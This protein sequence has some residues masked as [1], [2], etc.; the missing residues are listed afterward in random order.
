MAPNT[1]DLDTLKRQL[2]RESWASREE[3]VSTSERAGKFSGANGTFNFNAA[4][5]RTG[6]LPF[7]EHFEDFELAFACVWLLQAVTLHTNLG[8]I[9]C[10]IAC[11]EVPKA[12]EVGTHFHK[13]A[14]SSV[15][16]RENGK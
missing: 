16:F 9:K 7:V 10:E 6:W 12:A 1:I 8:D 3:K 15:C 4:F 13:D 11:D 5:R 2:T 14:F